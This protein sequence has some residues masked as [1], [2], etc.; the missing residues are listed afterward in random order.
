MRQKK[1]NMIQYE[2]NM[3]LKLK[4]TKKTRA[5]E[6]VNKILKFE[7]FVNNINFFDFILQFDMLELHLSISNANFLQQLKNST[8]KYQKQNILEI[9]N[10]CFRD[11]VYKWY[12]NQS[13]FDSKIDFLQNFNETLTKTFSFFFI[14]FTITL[15][16]SFSISSQTLVSNQFV[17]FA[18]CFATSKS[19]ISSRFSRISKS[20]SRLFISSSI[21]ISKRFYLIVNDLVV[22]FVEIS[23]LSNL[24][25]HQN[26]VFSSSIRR[27]IN[28]VFTIFQMRISIISQTRI[29]SYFKF[30]NNDQKKHEIKTWKT[31][32]NNYTI[33]TLICSHISKFFDRTKFVKSSQSK[34]TNFKESENVKFEIVES[35]HDY[36]IFK[37]ASNF[38]RNASLC[39]KII[40]FAFESAS[41][42]F[43]I[44]SFKNDH[45]STIYDDLTSTRLSFKFLN[46]CNHLSSSFYFLNCSRVCRICHETYDF[47]N[48]LHRH[49]KNNHRSSSSRRSLKKS[50]EKNI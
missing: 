25:H 20:I 38:F 41:F 17:L 6:I 23:K 30:L 43:K 47:N 44:K 14:E 36:L 11:F 31:K 33:W 34:L 12:E 29:T 21:F 7:I 26:N 28:L 37:I 24:L 27:F 2:K 16:V 39:E 5:I 48:V 13:N 50:Q 42:L 22:K 19:M 1:T 49:L 15:R 4:K 45:F 46:F 9:L 32:R 3:R 35:T 18:T 40:N 8:I 10:K